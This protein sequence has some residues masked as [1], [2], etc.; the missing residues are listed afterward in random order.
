M[1][2][3][4]KQLP[5]EN[6]R[7]N[8]D[9]DGLTGGRNMKI[10]LEG[11]KLGSSCS[12]KG[13]V[14]RNAIPNISINSPDKL[15][16][17][18]DGGSWIRPKLPA[19]WQ[20]AQEKDVILGKV[21]K[22]KLNYGDKSPPKHVLLKHNATVK[23]YCSREWK[24]LTFIDNVLCRIK[25]IR[26]LENI[27][28]E[29]SGKSSDE[30]SDDSSG[31]SDD[32]IDL[33]CPDAMQI[34]RVVPRAW[35]EGIFEM[36]HASLLGGHLGFDKI[37]PLAAQRFYWLGMARDFKRLLK[38]C[39]SCA[40]NKTGPGRSK[41]PL[42]QEIAQRVLERVSIDIAGPWEESETGNKYILAIQDYF[43]K[44]I[45]IYCIPNHRAPTVARCMLDYICRFGVP[46]K[47]HSDNGQELV[48]KLMQSL[49]KLFKIKK[50]RTTSYSPWSNGGIERVNKSIKGM[51]QHYTK[52]GCHDWDQYMMVVA[53]S[54]RA[55]K[56]ASTGYSPNML[57]FGRELNHPADLVYGRVE[58]STLDRDANEHVKSLEKQLR[59]VWTHTRQNM[60]KAA[61]IQQKSRARDV[62]DWQFK[63][64][65]IVYKILPRGA[66]IS[67]RWVGP[68]QVIAVVSKWLIE[69]E[70][71][72]RR[73]L[74]NANN[75]KPFREVKEG[76]LAP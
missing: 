67:P 6:T 33:R 17:D 35:R 75:L 54:Y 73:Y 15:E 65:D 21:I 74:V 52:P 12:S 4:N 39:H 72:H 37:Y 22:L 29:L 61:E 10:N 13:I 42:S 3:K 62:I 36:V 56:H 53:A 1:P 76:D 59:T 34:Q 43:T 18:D 32:P 9:E 14:G 60:M 50:T 8:I 7:H 24:D 47:L 11:C 44:W 66:K 40:E 46:E 63:P 49:Y 70:H 68:C 2:W 64:G 30:L 57:M 20:E 28:D 23:H 55:T 5:G 19:E 31:S 45:E 25:K 41:L 48:G 27:N 51:I 58:G 69:I 71:Q 16:A 26:K 38:S